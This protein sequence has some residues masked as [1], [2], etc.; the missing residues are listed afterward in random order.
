MLNKGRK[1]PTCQ[2][3]A[4]AG[5]AILLSAGAARAEVVVSDNRDGTF[6][7]TRTI[8]LGDGNPLYGTY[9]D[10][11]QSPLQTGDAGPGKLLNWFSYGF[12]GSSP[13]NFEL[14]GDPGTELAWNED[15]KTYFW[16]GGPLTTIPLNE[17][18][19][20]EFVDSSYTWKRYG[21][22]Y[23]ALPFSFEMNGGTPLIAPLAYLGVRIKTGPASYNY[24]W[25]LYENWTNPLMWA[26]ETTPNTP[27]Q[28]PI[29]TPGALAVG[30]TG[31]IV[32]RRRR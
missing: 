2:A 25:I 19:P 17:F 14:I 16:N 3:A 26:Y 4:V 1:L 23:L 22:H 28:I 5:A 12:T 13:G 24:G 32:L 8:Y 31:I 10:I 11:R 29:P 27:I 15:F 21:L 20:G 6:Q 9:L 30:I 7:W 18:A